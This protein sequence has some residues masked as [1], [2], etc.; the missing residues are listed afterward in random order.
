[1]FQWLQNIKM[2]TKLIGLFLLVGIVP[3]AVASF[4]SYESANTSLD[5]AAQLSEESLARQSFNQLVGLHDV[6]KT[7]IEAY[8]AERQGDMHVLVANVD[9]LGPTSRYSAR[10]P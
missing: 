7:Q 5:E 3:L 4:V 2:K 8:F 1:M 9:M 10:S 6:K